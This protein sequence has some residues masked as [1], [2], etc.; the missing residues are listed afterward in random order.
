[1]QFT[2][3]LT[4]LG[5]KRSKGEYEGRPYDSTN[6]F[7]QAEL[8]QGDDFVGQVGESI[9]WGTSENFEKIKG[10]KY[11]FSATATMQQVSNGKTS[12]T[13][14]LDLKPDSQAQAKQ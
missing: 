2:T 12:T 8:Q 7:Y 3:T 10:L 5:A 1:M 9:K 14:L 11:P 6:I 13:V 4:V